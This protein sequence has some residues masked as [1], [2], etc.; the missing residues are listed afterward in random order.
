MQL[1]IKFGVVL[2]M[3]QKDNSSASLCHQQVA[4]VRTRLFDASSLITKEE[5]STSGFEAPCR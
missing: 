5:V 2:F 3:F 1:K 4:P